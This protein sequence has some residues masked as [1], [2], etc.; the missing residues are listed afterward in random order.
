MFQGIVPRVAGGEE[1]VREWEAAA[2]ARRSKVDTYHLL[3]GGGIKK[4]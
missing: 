4:A 1:N 3:G 2:M